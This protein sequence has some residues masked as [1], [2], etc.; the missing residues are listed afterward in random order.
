MS[1]AG[2]RSV[3]TDSPPPPLHVL[4]VG[5]GAAGERLE[6]GADGDGPG[7]E[8]TTV[9]TAAAG[10]EHLDDAVDCVVVDG[11][12][13]GADLVSFVEDVVA[14][15]G[16]LPVVLSPADGSEALAGEAVAAGASGYVPRGDDDPSLLA[17]RVEAAVERARARP[18]ADRVH[19]RYQRLIHGA[20]DV[21]FVVDEAGTFRFVSPA[22]EGVLG[23][24]PADLEGTN[25]FDLVHED[26]RE[27]AMAAFSRAVEDPDHEPEVEFRVENASGEWRWLAVRG[28]NLLDDPVVGGLVVNARDVTE[29]VEYEQEL[30]AHERRFRQIAEHLPDTAIWMTD[31][32]FG[33]VQ[34]VS[35]G[36]ED[37]WGRPPEELY[38]HPE[39][40]ITAVHPEDQE[41]V[42][43]GMSELLSTA[44]TEGAP[45]ETRIEYRV[46]QPDGG[47]RWVRS[48]TVPILDGDDEVTH[49]V[50]MTVD[51]TEEKTRERRLEGYE[52]LAR[53]LEHG[54]CL[55]DEHGDVRFANDA[56]AEMLG[57]PREALEGMR[58]TE[59]VREGRLDP[60]V[61]DRYADLLRE[62]LSS[63]TDRERG[64]LEL[65][66]GPEAGPTERYEAHISLLPFEDRFR[67]TA[68]FLRPVASA[69]AAS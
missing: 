11:T 19:D 31:P 42:L 48:K 45:A 35:P 32:G 41:R 27:A 67:G 6:D 46:L 10:L 43:A 50:G 8:T 1:A 52:T 30:A 39:Q 15:R 18:S 2:E 57:L 9:A 20:T 68:V 21:V 5:D 59:V 61:P 60:S 17:D 62:L 36:Y 38:E 26:D 12:L 56:L 54:A 24:D 49:W 28:R 23:Y 22:V 29:R 14:A 40:F 13:D 37:I 33:D 4:V 69:D 65:E 16:D 47:V 55:L 58:V 64:V 44:E 34:Y 25:G 7:F 53:A 51:V 3:V 63:S 66:L